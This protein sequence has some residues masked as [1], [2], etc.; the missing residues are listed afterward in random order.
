MHLCLDRQAERPRRLQ[1]AEDDDRLAAA[2]GAIDEDLVRRCR[3]CRRSAHRAPVL[4]AACATVAASANPSK[5]SATTPGRSE[6]QHRGIGDRAGRA[7]RSG[8]SAPRAR[9]GSRSRHGP[10]WRL[11]PP[12]CVPRCHRRREPDGRNDHALLAQGA[13]EIRGRPG[14][15]TIAGLR[16][17]ALTAG[18]LAGFDVVERGVWVTCGAG[19][20]AGV[21]VSSAPPNRPARLNMNTASPSAATRPRTSTSRVWIGAAKL[22]GCLSAAD[23][24]T[25]TVDSRSGGDPHGQPRNG[26]PRGAWGCSTSA[27]S[28]AASSCR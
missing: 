10:A 7:S 23:V 4:C 27:R 17:G 24:E 15:R 18:V 11:R 6:D 20:A 25:F 13:G 16:A 21:T 26:R 3:R 9:S 5:R 19:V 28:F 22:T 1:T 14:L 8:P 2:V 12:H